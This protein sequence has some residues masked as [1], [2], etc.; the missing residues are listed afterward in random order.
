MHDDGS[1]ISILSIGTAVPQY[2]FSQMTIGNWMANSFPSQPSWARWLRGLYA[3]AG[4]ETRY[5]SIPD[6]GMLPLEARYSPGYEGPDVPGT[7]ERMV[8]YQR[9]SVALGVAAARRALADYSSDEP[10]EQ[11]AA[12]IT[13]LIIVSCTGFFAPEPGIAI[14]RQLGLSPTVKR[15]L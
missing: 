8:V 11:V 1:A 3:T 9:E 12:S 10:F 6:P 4:V 5:A 13:H 2:R 15:T 7:A 14:A